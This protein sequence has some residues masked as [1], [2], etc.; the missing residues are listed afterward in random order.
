MNKSISSIEREFIK[1]SIE[2]DGSCCFESSRVL[3]FHVLGGIEYN[4][5]LLG[6]LFLLK[7]KAFTTN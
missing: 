1:K 6:V 7:A 3:S 2:N 4:N 5:N